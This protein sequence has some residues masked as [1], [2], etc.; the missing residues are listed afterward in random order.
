MKTGLGKI[1][2]AVNSVLWRVEEENLRKRNKGKEKEMEERAEEI[3]LFYKSIN[4]V[5]RV[6]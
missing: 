4:G 2:W 5:N 1:V 3:F 6:R